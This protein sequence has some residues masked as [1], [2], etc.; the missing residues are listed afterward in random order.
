MEVEEFE[1]SYNGTDDGHMKLVQ[2]CDWL[3]STIGSYQAFQEFVDSGEYSCNGSAEEGR[4]G[5]GAG[6]VGEASSGAGS[7]HGN[8]LQLGILGKIQ[9]LKIFMT[10]LF[11]REKQARFSFQI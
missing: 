7:I 3:T 11:Q 8:R 4:S 9:F 1:E 10:R 5:S 2:E 6:S